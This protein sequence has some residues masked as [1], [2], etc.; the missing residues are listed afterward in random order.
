MEANMKDAVAEWI[1]L[2]ES[3]VKSDFYNAEMY[4]CN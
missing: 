1:P 3:I 2:L 4:V